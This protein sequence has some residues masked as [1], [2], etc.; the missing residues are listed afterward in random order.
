VGTMQPLSQRIAADRFVYTL[1]DRDSCGNGVLPYW[2]ARS[3][4][5]VESAKWA[6]L[7]LR[8]EAGGQNYWILKEP[9]EARSNR[10]FLDE[11]AVNYVRR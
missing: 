7:E 5:L 2:P 3:F 9:F 1:M 6:L 11:P 8:H 10:R 4:W